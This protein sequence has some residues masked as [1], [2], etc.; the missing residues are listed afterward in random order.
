SNIEVDIDAKYNSET[1]SGLLQK[2]LSKL[3]LSSE[4]CKTEIAKNL[5]GTI[6][7]KNI[8][9][10]EK[11]YN[12]LKREKLDYLRSDA[13]IPRPDL[14]A[15][16][17]DLKKYKN[18]L[19]NDKDIALELIKRD[20]WSLEFL[21]TDFRKDREFML[22]AF[23]KNQHS[24][25]KFIDRDLKKDINF[26]KEVM[27]RTGGIS[28]RYVGEQHKKNTDFLKEYLKNGSIFQDTWSNALIVCKT[29]GG[30]LPNKDY[31]LNIIKQ[32]GGSKVDPEEGEFHGDYADCIKKNLFDDVFFKFWTSE[33][34]PEKDKAI[35]VN[36]LKAKIEHARLTNIN[37]FRCVDGSGLFITHQSIK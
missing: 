7:K 28:L 33:Y 3:L 2:N 15:F 35:E 31:Y 6:L 21:N 16:H 19:Q 4:K 23:E 29:L 27:R 36:L 12:D 13:Y 30:S 11:N 18:N 10:L 5:I 9:L 32:C 1:Y 20:G 8:E 24:A 26:V 25:S 17:E 14:K 22:F 37:L 34:N